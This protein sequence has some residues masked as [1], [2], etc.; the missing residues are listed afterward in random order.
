MNT[1][2]HD[3][4]VG[5]LFKPLET[6][7]GEKLTKGV[8]YKIHLSCETMLGPHF[9]VINLSTGEWFAVRKNF[10]VEVVSTIPD[11]VEEFL[12]LIES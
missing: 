11:T 5:M 3:L 10:K 7:N 12:T 1:Y 6:F 8:S 4:E 2:L 9:T